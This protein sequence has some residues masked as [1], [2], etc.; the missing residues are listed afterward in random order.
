MM[1]VNPEKKQFVCNE[2]VPAEVPT[3]LSL[4]WESVSVIGNELPSESMSVCHHVAYW[5]NTG[6]S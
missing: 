6:T 4:Q 3:N 1:L 5:G 2:G